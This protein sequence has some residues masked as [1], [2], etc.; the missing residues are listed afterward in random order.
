MNIRTEGFMKKDVAR[1]TGIRASNIQFY[2]DQGIVVPEV[3]APSG[4]GTRRKYSKHNLLQILIA[5]KLVEHGVPLGDVRG[6]LDGF[7]DWCRQHI[8]LAE[9]QLRNV[10]SGEKKRISEKARVGK[11]LLQAESWDSGSLD[12]IFVWIHRGEG[13]SRIGVLHLGEEKRDFQ[14]DEKIGGDTTSFLILN[15]TD[16]VEKVTKL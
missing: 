11:M 12:S 15:I 8:D 1:L 16:L 10:P 14:S 4:K 13:M 3:D 9:D 6:I 7:D 2:T 5:K